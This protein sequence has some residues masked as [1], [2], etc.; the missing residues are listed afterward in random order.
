MVIEL[1]PFKAQFF[2][3]SPLIKIENIAK[4]ILNDLDKNYPPNAQGLS[5]MLP[6]NW[7]VEPIIPEK[8]REGYSLIKSFSIDGTNAF[9]VPKDKLINKTLGILSLKEQNL[10]LDAINSRKYKPDVSTRVIFIKWGN[11][12]LR[13]L[14]KIKSPNWVSL[15]IIFFISLLIISAIV[16]KIWPQNRYYYIDFVYYPPKLRH[17]SFS[18]SQIYHYCAQF[19]KLYYDH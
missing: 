5:R 3:A 9:E 14:S 12:E 19:C 13:V 4:D 8:M 15:S 18:S 11:N 1:S 10:F 7:W 2:D 17:P 6:W 16:F